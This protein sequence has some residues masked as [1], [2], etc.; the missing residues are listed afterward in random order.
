[1]R[2]KAIWSTAGPMILAMALWPAT[3]GAGLRQGEALTQFQLIPDWLVRVDGRQDTDARVYR[4]YNPSVY[5]L[6][7]P[8]FPE[9]ILLWPK[10]FKVEALDREHL[11]AGQDGRLSVSPGYVTRE[12]GRFELIEGEP[13]FDLDGKKVGLF[14][15]PP[16]T[17]YLTAQQIQDYDTR[18]RERAKAYQPDPES[19]AQI[20]SFPREA[21]VTVYLGTWCGHCQQE[22]PKAMSVESRLEG[23]K[24]RFRYF[25]LPRHER[26]GLGLPPEILSPDGLI[27]D[28][29]PTTVVTLD[30]KIIGQIVRQD[31]ER[32]EVKLSQILAQV[33]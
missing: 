21:L 32:P 9:P 15:R 26:A 3:A 31:V 17:G 18:F 33:K 13:R 16:L 11:Q 23:S 1:M 30:G 28:G 5:L 10:S 2:H 12:A 24:I 29:L 4:S 8:Q 25:G 14:P 7:G 19:L 22:V 6:M 27:K 20:R